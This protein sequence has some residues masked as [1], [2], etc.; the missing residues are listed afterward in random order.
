MAR[1]RG[2]S[3]GRKR[4]SGASRSDASSAVRA[5]VLREDAAVVHAVGE[6]VVLDLLGG[7]AP[8]GGL[9]LLAHRHGEPGAPVDGDPAHDLRRREVLQLPA[10]LPDAGVGL[11]PVLERL[12]DLL[13]QDRPHPV[14]EVVDRLGVQVDRVEQGAPDVVLLL[15]VRGVADPD[16]PR[17]GVPGQVVELGLHELTLA[18]DAVHDLQVV[19][20]LGDVGDEGEEVDGLPVEA[21]G[22]HAP[23]GEGRVADPGEAVVVVA[24]AAR[25]LGQ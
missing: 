15:G 21:E 13:L 20:L 4:T 9:A 16:R 25:C 23:Q 8:L 7:E 12:A 18:A 1:I 5:V 3:G 17:A 22:V 19:V 6:D 24:V 14:V 2:S 11:A 10:H